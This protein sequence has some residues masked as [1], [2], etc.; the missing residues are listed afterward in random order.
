MMWK[1]LIEKLFVNLRDKFCQTGGAGDGPRS[2][3]Q[4][5]HMKMLKLEVLQLQRSQV[6]V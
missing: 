4:D 3:R 6:K 1:I 5:A 2:G